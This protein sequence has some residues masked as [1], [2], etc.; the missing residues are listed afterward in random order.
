MAERIDVRKFQARR[1]AEFRAN[2]GKLNPPLDAV[3][4]LVLITTGAKS[5]RQHA[6]PMSYTSDDDRFVVVAAAGGAPEHPAWYHNLVA[7]PEVT[8]EVGGET[9]QARATV[10]SEPERSRIFAQHAAQ[11]PN[12]IDF[13]RR[14]T[15]QLPVVILERIGGWT[16]P[17]APPRVGEG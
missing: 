17:P 5:G 16:S 8:V 10:V 14:T 7:N 15:R 11:R 9:F 6:T 2:G 13:Q 4:L 12:F 3:P 1:I